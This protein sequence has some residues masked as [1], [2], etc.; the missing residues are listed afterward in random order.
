MVLADVHRDKFQLARRNTIKTLLIVGCCFIVCWSQN[1]VLYLMFNLGYDLDW[2]SKYYHFT[3]LMVF[4]NCTVN[5][6]IYLIKY[7]DYQ[8]ALREFIR[9]KSTSQDEF[10]S[11]NSLSSVSALTNSRSKCWFEVSVNAFEIIYCS[12]LSATRKAVMYHQNLKYLRT[13]EITKVS[14]DELR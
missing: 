14:L 4:V 7:Q 10:Q 12:F 9:C 8:I 11:Q 2:N 5:P 13:E 6:L 1:Q 3:V